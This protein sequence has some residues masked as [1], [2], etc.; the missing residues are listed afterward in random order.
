MK[1]PSEVKEVLSKT[2]PYAFATASA[3][4]MPNVVPVGMLIPKDDE[5]LWLVDNYL[6][7]TLANVKENPHASIYVW[8]PEC[9]NSYQ[10]KCSVAVENSGKDYEDAVAFA[11]SK[12]ET[13]PAKNLL[14][15]KVEEIYYVTPG[16]NAGK[17]I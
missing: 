14:K 7:K 1:M 9:P 17:K 10:I 5:T 3:S 8:N 16:P 12:K 4:G 15:L 2:K 13:F 6:N 11:H